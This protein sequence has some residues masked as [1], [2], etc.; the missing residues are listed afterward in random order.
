LRQAG[1]VI[2]GLVVFLEDAGGNEREQK[3]D[4]Y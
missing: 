2:V 4:C 3:A 1:Q